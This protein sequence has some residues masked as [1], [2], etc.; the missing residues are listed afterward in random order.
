MCVF[1]RVYEQ[2]DGERERKEREREKARKRER[3]REIMRILCGRVFEICQCEPVD[4]TY[5]PTYICMQIHKRAHLFFTAQ[6]VEKRPT[7]HGCH[8]RARVAG[9]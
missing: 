4:S 2:G 3:E 5:S 8:R 1:V 9:M 6:G 7:R